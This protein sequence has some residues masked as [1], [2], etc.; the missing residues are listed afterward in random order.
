M[1][2]AEIGGE[3]IGEE[4]ELTQGRQREERRQIAESAVDLQRKILQVRVARE[5]VQASRPDTVRDQ[6][7]ER[8]HSRQAFQLVLGQ[9][10]LKPGNAPK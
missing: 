7:F 3:P 6:L 4:V 2:K 1:H 9:M 5:Q 10:D 8:R